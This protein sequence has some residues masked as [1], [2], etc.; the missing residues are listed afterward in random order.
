MPRVSLLGSLEDA[1]EAADHDVL[2]SLAVKRLENTVRI[3]P[4]APLSH[5]RRLLELGQEPASASLR[6][7][8]AVLVESVVERRVSLAEDER[9]LEAAGFDD[10][11]EV[12]DARRHLALFPAGDQRSSDAAAFRQFVLGQTCSCPRLADRIGSAH[13]LSLRQRSGA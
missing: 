3:E 6:R 10:R 8:V 13:D 5:A 4:R 7:Q 12:V 1:R 11:E 9:D 2:H